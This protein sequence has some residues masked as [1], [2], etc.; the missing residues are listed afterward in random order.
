MSN[1]LRTILPFK[2]GKFSRRAKANPTPI[3]KGVVSSTNR[4]V[5]MKLAL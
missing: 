4:N 5:L 1:T 2:K 3:I